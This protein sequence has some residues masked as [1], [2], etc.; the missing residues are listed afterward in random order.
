MNGGL[1][2]KK[3]VLEGLKGET[4]L[5]IASRDLKFIGKG[6]AILGVWIG[7]ALGMKA[8]ME[9]ILA[10]FDSDS[11]APVWVGLCMLVL[12]YMFVLILV[13]GATSAILDR[14][15]RN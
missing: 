3:L 11:G 8:L 15:D 1:A 7:W 2:S 5:N 10:I 13:Y 14:W 6:I 4:D 9:P 12:L